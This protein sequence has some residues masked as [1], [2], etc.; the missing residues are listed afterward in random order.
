MIN[1]AFYF[2]TFWR[3]YAGKQAMLVSP[4][5]I[6][7]IPHH[8]FQCATFQHVGMGQLWTVQR[9]PI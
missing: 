5:S 1:S 7:S 6:C 9:L 2:F 8:K 4:I 3:D